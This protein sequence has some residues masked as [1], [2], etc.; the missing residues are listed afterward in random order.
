MRVG[1]LRAGVST[2]LILAT[3]G[4]ERMRITTAGNVGIG[5]T[6]PAYKFNVSNN[7]AEG[8]EFR[9]GNTSNINILQN[10]NR[11]TSVYTTLDL[12]ASDFYLKMELLLL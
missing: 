5:T 11:A 4:T 2:P 6:S 12:R 3:T 7:D 10:Y 9:P 1:F 8:F